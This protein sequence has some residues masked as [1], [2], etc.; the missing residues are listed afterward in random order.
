MTLFQGTNKEWNSRYVY[1][2]FLHG[3]CCLFSAIL[4]GLNWPRILMK[5]WTFTFFFSIKHV[6]YKQ[7]VIM[8]YSSCVEKNYFGGNNIRYLRCCIYFLFFQFARKINQLSLKEFTNNVILNTRRYG[9]GL[10]I[11]IRGYGGT[12]AVILNS[13]VV[14][15]PTIDV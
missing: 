7:C 13:I 6:L 5:K 9:V 3:T 12:R 2:I 1:I 10:A 11:L 8:F 14:S 4:L 15:I